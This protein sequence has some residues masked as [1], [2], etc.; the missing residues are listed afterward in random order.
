MQ[1]KPPSRTAPPT[2]TVGEAPV[3]TEARRPETTVPVEGE[4]Q[5]A[6]AARVNARQ[7]AVAAQIRAHQAA[8]AAG[9]NAQA[10]AAGA[11]DALRRATGSAAQAVTVPYA[12]GRSI[13]EDLAGSARRP[14]VVA[15]WAGLVGLAALE[16]LEWPA[17]VALGVGI[18]V[19]SA[20]K[21]A[22]RARA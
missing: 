2:G 20:A 8:T 14:D 7:A 13:A 16:V 11:E 6:V 1:K 10:P 3:A 12:L 21:G 18:A 9:A 17:A 19:A 15:Y 5:E 22:R 4:K